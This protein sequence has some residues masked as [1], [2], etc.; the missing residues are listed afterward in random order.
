MADRWINGVMIDCVRITERYDYYRKLIPQLAEWGYNTLFWHFTDDQGCALRL[1]SRPELSSRYALTRDQTQRLIR[2]A[3]RHGIEVIP[4]VE[5]LGHTLYITHLKRYRH[6]FEGSATHFNAMCPS[7]PQTLEILRDVLAETAE[8]FPSDFLHVGL[9]EVQFGSCPRCRRRKLPDWRLFADHVEAIHEIVTGLGKR[10]ILWG[11]HLVKDARIARRVPRDCLVAHWDYFAERPIER[12]SRKLLDLGFE[13][14]GCPATGRVFTTTVP[15]ETNLANIRGFA[16]IG[17]KHRSTKLTEIRST[18]LTEI[19]RRGV[20]GMVNTVWCPERQLGCSTHWGIALGAALFDSPKV[21]ERKVCERFV[22][23]RYG[24]SR[25]AAAARAIRELHAAAPGLLMLRKVLIE[26]AATHAHSITP[27]DVAEAARRRAMLAAAGKR[28]AAAKP[29]VTRNKGEFAMW[30]LAAEL[31]DEQLS[32]FQMWQDVALLDHLRQEALKRRDA[33]AAKQISRDTAAVLGGAARRARRS[34]T[35]AERDWKR[36]RHAADPRRFGRDGYVRQGTA[37]P[38]LLDRTATFIERMA[39]R[40]K[41]IGR[42]GRGRLG[43]PGNLVLL[44]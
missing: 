9:D 31:L 23:D 7:H 14:L 29:R 1:K 26:K 13:V 32:R 19:R 18:K 20:V 11:D 17:H 24:L 37:L 10:M 40:A 4:E 43:L 41:R 39:A 38:G 8:I 22:G 2:L 30:I 16:R 3:A 33:P 25:G 12:D 44:E 36:V 21:D 6:L 42:T 15:D 35:R 5:S 34:A 27:E 28:L